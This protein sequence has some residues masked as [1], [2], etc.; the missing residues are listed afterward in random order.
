MTVLG[1]PAVPPRGS[2]NLRG[3]EKFPAAAHHELANTQLRRNIGKATHTIRAKRLNVTDELPDWQQL[4][5]AGAAVKRDVLGRLPELLIELEAAV[6]ARGGVVH[7]AADAT[8]ANAIVTDLVRKTG[9][10]EV[11]KVKSMATQ[12]IGLNEHLEDQGIT[13]YETDLAELIVQLGHDKPSHILVP[14][15]HR[16][17]AEIREIFLR[18]MP[19]VDPDL[20]DNPAHL[21]AAAR[22]F[23]RRKFMTV[24]VAVSGANFGIAETGTLA[25]VESEGNGR[26][27]LTLPQTLITVM[28]IEKLLPTFRDLE[29]FLQLL[30][31]SST[32]ERMN[33]YTSMW[34]GVT[35]G[36]GPQEFHLV[37]LD[38]GRTAALADGVGREALHCIRCSACLNVCP[39]YERT[40]GHAYG[41]TYPGP[42]GAVLSPQLAGMDTPGDPNATLPFASSLCG[43]CF[44]ACPVKIDIPSLLVELRHQK[45]EHAPFGVEAAAM[46]AASLAMSSSRR[47]TAAQKAVGLGRLL[48]GRK[49]KITTLPGP[50]GGW[51][52]A[53]DI[54]APPKQTFRQWWNSDEGRAALAQAREKGRQQ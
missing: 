34:T 46:K 10:D 52:E 51:T 24:P 36:D 4:R 27:C 8:E 42:I 2:G 26:M 19:D 12:E 45:V 44:D 17:R 21:A 23:L 33:P 5:D 38:N 18:E 15:I 43:A 29:V 28:G 31:R 20:D 9:S 40:G 3:T 41:S 35:P 37:L 54:P 6:V 39:V 50:L 25:V 7:W 16:N 11:I 32:G 22:K 49:G 30:P 47:W 14:A 48:A 13:A 53:R 1:M